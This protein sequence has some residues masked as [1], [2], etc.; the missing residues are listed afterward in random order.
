ML[1]DPVRIIELKAKLRVG[2]E[3]EY[4]D[5]TENRI[6]KA[7]I[8]KIKRTTVTVRHIDDGACWTIPY[9]CIN[10]NELGVLVR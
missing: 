10:R 6:I 4:C 2:M 7:I 1:D 3:I 5:S 8:L 9:Y